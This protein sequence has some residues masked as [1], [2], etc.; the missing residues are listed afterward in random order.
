MISKSQN[1]K[2]YYYK[3]LE[4]GYQFGKQISVKLMHWSKSLE[5][6]MVRSKSCNMKLKMSD[7]IF[8]I[9]SSCL[10]KVDNAVVTICSPFKKKQKSLLSL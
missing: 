10:E 7:R 5:P 9:L 3:N 4:N 2:Y 8:Q 6:R 1:P